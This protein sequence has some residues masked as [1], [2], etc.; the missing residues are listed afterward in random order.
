MKTRLFLVVVTLLFLIPIVASADGNPFEGCYWVRG[1]DT[2]AWYWE[3]PTGDQLA[4]P[5]WN[6]GLFVWP[7]VLEQRTFYFDQEYQ[8]W[9]FV[10][11]R[12]LTSDPRKT[13]W[14]EKSRLNSQSTTLWGRVADAARSKDHPRITK[15]IIDDMIRCGVTTRIEVEWG[16]MTSARL[17]DMMARYSELVWD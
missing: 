6:G 15:L 3:M 8:E 1:L 7:L 9:H 13:E 4:G 2:P 17:D 5:H 14:W 11:T 10:W 16:R 12:D